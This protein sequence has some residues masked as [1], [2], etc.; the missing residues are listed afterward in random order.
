MP[1]NL[2]CT[3]IAV[4][5]RL[6]SIAAFTILYP[7]NPLNTKQADGP[8]QPEFLLAKEEGINCS[9]F[10]FDDF[11]SGGPL[12]TRP[13]LKPDETVLYRGWMMTVEQY[14]KLCKIIQKKGSL[15]I[16]SSEEYTRCH[17]LPGWYEACSDL[18]TDSRFFEAD[19][20]IVA[21][22]TKLGWDGFFVKD[23]VKSNTGSA[24]SVAAT[25]D[26]I[27]TILDQLKLYRG[28]IE[29]GVGEESEE[30][31]FVVGG[32]LY[33]P[34]SDAEV[35]TIV[36]SVAKRV[37]APFFSVDIVQTMDGEWRVVE[38]GD[39]QVSDKKEWPLDMFVGQVLSAIA[40]FER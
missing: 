25:V 35:P 15:P 37:K 2:L 5:I 31:Y 26:D 13:T 22:A 39:G 20:D 12:R 19:S 38:L 14:R 33:G 27:P 11:A 40:T 6:E 1:G 17:H 21:E 23:F 7:L 10:D 18:T 24:G 16:T 8:Y 29:G 30:R 9:L 32:D 34:S 4:W 28:E 36:Y 3:L